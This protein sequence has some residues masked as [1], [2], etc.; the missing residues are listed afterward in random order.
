MA[1][2]LE[3][4][5]TFEV[6]D[7]IVDL[8]LL[9]G[10]SGVAAVNGPQQLELEATYFDTV[11]LDLARARITLRRRLGG[12]DEGWH[13]KLPTAEGRWEVHEPVGEE[14]VVPPALLAVVHAVT[15]GTPL[16]PVA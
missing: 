10:V 3:I 11:D 4:E 16:E 13:L 5:T 7:G 14:L 6:P 15:R 1:D 12:Q 8:S 2:H 9:Q